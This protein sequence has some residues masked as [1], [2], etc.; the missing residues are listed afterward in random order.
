VNPVDI[1]IIFATSGAGASL[2]LLTSGMAGGWLVQP[3][4]LKG[5]PVGREP[6]PGPNEGGEPAP[7]PK[8]EPKP[9]PDVPKDEPKPGPKPKDEPDEQPP[10][11]IPFCKHEM[12]NN[13]VLDIVVQELEPYAIIGGSAP[14]LRV[15]MAPWAIDSKM[16]V[17]TIDYYIT[18]AVLETLLRQGSDPAVF[19]S[20][21]FFYPGCMLVPAMFA[22]GTPLRRLADLWHE[23][24]KPE[25]G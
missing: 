3:R 4:E 10:P 23:G 13:L 9:G 2:L 21:D 5:M 20:G 1:A 18:A 16:A 12:L 11:V 7:L 6:T 22:P 15:R 19:A 14:F 24:Q 25:D 8:D 17:G